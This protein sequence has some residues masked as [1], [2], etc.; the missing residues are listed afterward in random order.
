MNPHSEMVYVDSLG[1]QYLIRDVLGN[2]DCALLALLHSPGFEAPVSGA[3]EL[4][5]G[6]VSF[7][8][9]ESREACSRVYALLGERNET[10]F[11]MYLTRMLDPGFW[12][13]TVAFV[14]A[15]MAYGVEI[16]THFFN[17]KGQPD[18][19]STTAFLRR[20]IPGYED[21]ELEENKAVHVFFHQYNQMKRCKPAMY[22]HFATMV[23][24]RTM[25]A[26]T[27]VT[28][29]REVE[30]FN[31]PWWLTNGNTETTEDSKARKPK[32]QMNKDER[33]QYNQKI[34]Y[35]YLKM[36]NRNEQLAEKMAEKIKIAE[37]R[38]SEIAAQL[39]IDVDD[40]DLEVRKENC[41]E[42]NISTAMTPVKTLTHKYDRRSWKQRATIIF[43]YLHPQIG[44]GNAKDV[45]SL[46]GVNEHTLLGWLSQTKMIQYWITLVESMVA[47]TAVSSLEPD[48]QDLYCHIDPKST[49][50]TQKY[51]RR[52]GN[53]NSQLKILFKGGKVRK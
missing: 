34:T 48:V 2:G 41:M 32:K 8:R 50:C 10:T 31:N 33:K 5:R 20:H 18:S 29:N 28:L 14:W 30:Q 21:M 11:D 44:N 36:A 51:R 22:N 12:V 1:K 52:L 27:I 4:R 24:V 7:A 26:D 39:N 6:I 3:T 13:G 16:K 47:E 15:T 38:T 40:M 19:T 35:E 37:N 17:D 49:V 25:A 42:E 45:A 46:T 53:S 43:L 23:L 9:G